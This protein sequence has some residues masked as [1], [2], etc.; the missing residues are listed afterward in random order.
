MSED[1]GTIRIKA[2]ELEMRFN[3][4]GRFRL[5]SLPFL[6]PPTPPKVGGHW[7]LITTACCTAD[8][9]PSQIVIETQTGLYEAYPH[10]DVVVIPVNPTTVY[11]SQQVATYA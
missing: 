5:V 6:R 1:S 4:G 8:D 9:G 2:Q 3:S 10:D 7:P 11:K